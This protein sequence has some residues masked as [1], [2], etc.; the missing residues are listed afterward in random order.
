MTKIHGATARFMRP[1]IDVAT[2]NR[3]RHIEV[4]ET[5]G[6]T[7]GDDDRQRTARR[8]AQPELIPFASVL[9]RLPV[10]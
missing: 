6:E 4:I 1:I 3:S 2:S 7:L 10:S 5:C 9:R 8:I